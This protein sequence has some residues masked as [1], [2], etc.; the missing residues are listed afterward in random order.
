MVDS[1]R[2]HVFIYK[3]LFIEFTLTSAA[4]PGAVMTGP[5]FPLTDPSRMWIDDCNFL[6]WGL[7]GIEW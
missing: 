6:H 5:G 3:L 7:D 4:E 1:L 2:K